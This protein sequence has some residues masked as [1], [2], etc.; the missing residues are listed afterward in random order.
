MNPLYRKMLILSVSIAAFAVGMTYLLVLFKVQG[1]HRD[2]RHGRFELIAKE[3]DRIVER[4]MAL[5]LNF[6]EL[7]SLPQAMQRRQ[8]SDFAISHID[9]LDAQGKTIYSTEPARV[10]QSTIA[11]VPAFRTARGDLWR[12]LADDD[13]VAGAVVKNNFD[14]VEGYVAVAYSA[15][16]G[17]ATH[18]QMRDGL[19]PVAL[20]AFGVSAAVLF[21]A[22][23]LLAWR[24]ERDVKA[25][26]SR[27]T[28][29]DASAKPLHG[30]WDSLIRATKS[31]FA[32][33]RGALTAWREQ[34][35]TIG[36]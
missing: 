19:R 21:F 29:N 20:V 15:K 26:A 25:A 22:L 27:L 1:T 32:D 6:S 10:G 7:N 2:L 17:R 16:E 5:G 35:G 12:Y 36:K 8:Q 14:V 23:S 28:G 24:F 3:I 9:I 31:Q 18:E 4:S 34:H 30:G 13:A 33:A 11:W